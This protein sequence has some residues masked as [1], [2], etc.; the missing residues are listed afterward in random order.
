MTLDA[1]KL[2][3]LYAAKGRPCEVEAGPAGLVVYASTRVDAEAIARDLL[4]AVR[5]RDPRATRSEA[6][7]DDDEPSETAWW[8]MVEFDWRRL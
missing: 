6:K 1:R 8:A 4:G 5:E 2:A 3:A 7:R